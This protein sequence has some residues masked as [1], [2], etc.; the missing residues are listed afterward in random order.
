MH[1]L[2]L[3]EALLRRSEI[4]VLALTIAALLGVGRRGG[5]SSHIYIYLS[6]TV[7]YLPSLGLFIFTRWVYSTLAFW[8]NNEDYSPF[9][10]VLL[11]IFLCLTFSRGDSEVAGKFSLA[12]TFCAN[13]Y[14]LVSGLCIF[15]Q[16]PG[17]ILYVI[18][19]IH[20]LCY[21]CV[22]GAINFF[23]RLIFHCKKFPRESFPCHLF[24]VSCEREGVD[25]IYY[26]LS[27]DTFGVAV[28]P[29]VLWGLEDKI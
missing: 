16:F 24:L 26:L 19:G 7:G 3:V 18:L 21:R 23:E 12:F 27:E 15:Y 25:G 17:G 14:D 4:F 13:C 11:S 8:I 5:F 1:V 6:N 20:V 10:R 29:H 2:S 28:F 22:T 9:L